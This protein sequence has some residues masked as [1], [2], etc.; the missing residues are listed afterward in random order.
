[1][2]LIA[3]E[4]LSVKLEGQTVLSDISLSIAPGEIV[5]I[6]GPNGSGK[7]TLLRALLGLIV[8][9]AGVVMRRAGVRLGYVPQRLA[10]D[11]SMPMTVARFL[12]LPTRQS[13]QRIAAILTHVEAAGLEGRQLRD[14]SGGQFQRVLLDTPIGQAL[15][16]G[17][18]REGTR[19]EIKVQ[20]EQQQARP[21]TVA[22]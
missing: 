18:I 11:R 22:E 20:V 13:P 4:H 10:I 17:I 5:T 14:L 15:T 21:R 3:A 1:M 19:R 7:T 9:D 8:P 16:L 2:S 6:V 12:S